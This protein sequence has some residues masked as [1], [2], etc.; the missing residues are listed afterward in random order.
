MNGSIWEVCLGGEYQ[1]V[2][3][4]SGRVLG[5]KRGPRFGYEHQQSA[6]RTS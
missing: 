6:P 4:R 5:R 2:N 1:K 3:K